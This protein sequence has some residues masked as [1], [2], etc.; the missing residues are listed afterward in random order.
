MIG[1]RPDEDD[2]D[3]PPISSALEKRYESADENPGATIRQQAIRQELIDA[4]QTT[5]PTK[6]ERTLSRIAW[7]E[8][9]IFGHAFPEMHLLKRLH[10]LNQ[11]LFPQD[12]EQ[13]IQLMDHI[14]TIV[15][16]VVLRK[17]PRQPATT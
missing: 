16:E 3:L 13:D 6:D 11:E 14:D 12:K 15:K 5:I 7:C 9:Q 10:N 4:Q 2:E 17:Q 8:Q 1:S